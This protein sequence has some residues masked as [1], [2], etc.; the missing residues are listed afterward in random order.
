MVASGLIVSALSSIL[1]RSSCD[2]AH[3]RFS[4]IMID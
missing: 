2:S 1:D 4:R 3:S